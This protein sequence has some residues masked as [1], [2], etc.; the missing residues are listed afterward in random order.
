MFF[1][2]HYSIYS[3][4]TIATFIRQIWGGFIRRICGGFIRL[5]Q[6]FP[7]REEVSPYRFTISMKVSKWLNPWYYWC[8]WQMIR[9]AG[10]QLNA[11]EISLLGLPSEERGNVKK[12]KEA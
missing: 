1:C 9:T 3:I 12:R 10:D 11:N 7:A 6:M 5:R 4:F 8:A 2:W